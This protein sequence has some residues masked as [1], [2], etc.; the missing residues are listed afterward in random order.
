MVCRVANTCRDL[1]ANPATASAQ[2]SHGQTRGRSPEWGTGLRAAVELR[3]FE[4]LTS[5][6]PWAGVALMVYAEQRSFPYLQ[7][8]F[9]FLVA[10]GWVRFKTVV[11]RCPLPKSSHGGRRSGGLPAP[12]LPLRVM[13]R[14]TALAVRSRTGMP[15]V[16]CGPSMPVPARPRRRRRAGSQTAD[17]ECCRFAAFSIQRGGQRGGLG[18]HC[19]PCLPRPLRMY[20]R[21]RTHMG[22]ANAGHRE[23]PGPAWPRA[24][25][26][27]CTK[28]AKRDCNATHHEVPGAIAPIPSTPHTSDDWA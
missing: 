5:S 23:A 24:V 16:I 10:A 11:T 4:P 3:G 8:V 18:A 6:M 7:G 20:R 27:D 28:A 22:T 9:A 19:L 2:A 12:L 14:I 1:G 13:Y 15:P 17:W 25:A 26:R 21:H